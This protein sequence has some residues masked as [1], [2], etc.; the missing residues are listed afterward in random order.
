MYSSLFLF[1][2]PYS[3]PFLCIVPSDFLHEYFAHDKASQPLVV[4]L[5]ATDPSRELRLLLGQ[6]RWRTKTRLLFGNALVVVRK[7]MDMMVLFP[8]LGLTA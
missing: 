3:T 7:R 6:P 8:S 2:V 5:L 1:F 4:F